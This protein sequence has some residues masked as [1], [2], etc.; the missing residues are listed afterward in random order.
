LK[1]LDP[2]SFLDLAEA[3]I[4][5]TLGIDWRK[6]FPELAKDLRKQMQDC[7]CPQAT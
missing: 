1:L 7:I 4:A 5:L 3:A 6:R 2:K